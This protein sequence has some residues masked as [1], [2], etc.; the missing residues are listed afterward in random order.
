M[1]PRSQ[2]L[3][4]V[5]TLFLFGSC[6]TFYKYHVLGFT[7]VPDKMATVWQVQGK[8]Q[9]EATGGPIKVSLILPAT[10]QYR[11][12]VFQEKISDDYRCVFTN[13]GNIHRAVWTR[14]DSFGPQVIYYNGDFFYTEFTETSSPPA[15]TKPE[16][17]LQGQF[18]VA[19]QD[20]L[21]R[22]REASTTDLGLVLKVL[23]LMEDRKNN[24]STRVLL[25]NVRYRRVHME[26]VAKI[27]AMAEIH[28][29][30]VRGLRLKDHYTQRSITTF[31]QV[32]LDNKWILLDPNSLTEI[33]YN[34]ALLWPEGTRGLLDVF[35][36]EDSRI[37][38][39]VSSTQKNTGRLAITAGLLEKN[40]LV[41]FSIYSLPL[42][43]QNTFRIILLI[44]LGALVVV[45]L[46]NIIGIRTSGTFMPILISLTFLQT[47]LFLGLTLFL[48]V[49]GVGL[50]MRS[51]L[52]HLN[53]LLVPR[54]G[55]VL[56][57]V[58]IIYAAVGII[59]HKVG[60]ES[61]LAITFFPMIILSWTIERMSVLWEEEGP[62]EVL[63]QGTGSLLT[64]S[65]AYL[66][67]SSP[68]VAHLAFNFPEL[69]L[70]VLAIIIMIGSYSGFRLIE[71]FR[72][73]P[74]TR[75]Q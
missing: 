23:E 69:L 52:S 73:E 32:Y 28:S 25:K 45:I 27:L 6:L 63:I 66:F 5:S 33:P 65:V 20:I 37:T 31:I 14:Q 41:D 13:D 70:V 16:D 46:R 1:K 42:K 55:A 54:I 68:I 10:E 50:I 58:I 22:A 4:L 11:K 18:R 17:V 67:M 35:G 75:D 72:F 8:I 7:L 62:Q 26:Q 49:V 3:L 61:G 48:I 12:T 39:S 30:V 64:A 2:F 47:S 59:S 24:P 40:K 57:F 15:D 21:L 29:K 19:G 71:L 56:V 9:F 53:L 34:E 38:L 74:M 60:W 51:Y 43:D 36:G 44:P